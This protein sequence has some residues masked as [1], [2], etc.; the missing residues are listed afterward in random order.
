MKPGRWITLLTTLVLL[1][2][3]VVS[4]SSAPSLMRPLPFVFFDGVG[5]Y[6]ALIV[7]AIAALASWM[8]SFVLIR[9]DHLHA[10]WSSDLV[11]GGPQKM[12]LRPTPRIGGL[13]ILVGMFVALLVILIAEMFFYPQFVMNTSYFKLILLSTLPAFIG[14]ITED[15]TKRVS[16][17]NRLL[18]TMASAAFAIMLIGA[19]LTR[20][21]I[22]W[23]DQTLLAVPLIA[24]L[25]T[26]FAVAGIANS[27]N[28]I[29]GFHGLS[30][31][32]CC[33]VLLSL[34]Y[35]GYLAQD[36]LVIYLSISL[37]GALIGFLIWNWPRGLIFLGDGGAYLVGFLI[38][39][40]SILLVM[41][42]PEVS[43]WFPLVL[44]IFPFT[45]TLYSVFRRKF[46]LNMNASEPDR[47]HMHHLIH[48]RIMSQSSISSPSLNREL[49]N[50]K[51]AKY[52]WATNSI[53]A[54]SAIMAWDST[55]ISL[56]LVGAYA[57]LYIWLYRC[58][59]RSILAGST[60]ARTSAVEVAPSKSSSAV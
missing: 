42:N 31:G 2:L 40:I 32:F 14:G 3:A 25:F 5:M 17:L 16:P 6:A 45:E 11:D 4:L 59:D 9:F 26:A 23:V 50:P 22:P 19:T 60:H 51:V 35:V 36:S 8:V 18:F 12:H 1:G 33:I 21:D 46:L 30:A 7:A 52:V 44:V 10:N 41:R 34:A 47:G 28:I 37:A 13:P 38:A 49:A 55:P 15:L 57:I 43:P 54:V 20:T 48:W 27:I 58:L 24:V 39:E 53:V 29:D 56:L